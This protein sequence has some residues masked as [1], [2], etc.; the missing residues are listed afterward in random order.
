M[1][2]IGREGGED[3]RRRAAMPPGDHLVAGVEAGLEALR[4]HGVV[5][6]VAHVVLA[7]PHHLDRRAAQILG[8]QRRLDGEVALG[9]AAEAA[10]EQRRL[11]GHLGRRH[12]ERGGDVVARL[13]GALHRRPDLPLA[14]AHAGDGRRRLHGGVVEMGR[15]VLGRDHLGGGGQ[16]LVDV[17]DVALDLAGLLHGCF[18]LRPIGLGVVRRVGAVVPGDLERLAALDRR[19]G[20]AGDDGHAAERPELVGRGRAGKRHDLLHARHLHGRAGVDRRH[21]AA[22]HRRPGD[23]RE[24]HAGHHHVLAVDGLAGGDVDDVGDAHVALADVAEGARRPSASPCRRPAPAGRP[25]RRRARRSRACGRSACARPR[26]AA[27]GPRRRPPSRSRRPPAPASAARRH[28]SGA[29]AGSNG[30][31]CASRRY[32]GCRRCARRPATARRARAPSRRRARRRPSWAEPCARHRCPSRR[33]RR[34][35]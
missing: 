13:T 6:A 27:P 35:C 29:S 11:H 31:R 3:G 15:V 16:R 33:G 28:R 32:P 30:A 1:L 18:E 12:A 10:A 14:M 5:E 24:L 8:Q 26:A 17:A 7:R 4:R 34:R 20:V 21:L 19:P 23:D 22:D 9:L 2:R 25:Q